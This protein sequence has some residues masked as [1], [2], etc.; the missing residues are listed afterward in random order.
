MAPGSLAALALLAA[1]SQDV[2]ANS[3]TATPAVTPVPGNA[4]ALVM[5]RHCVACHRAAG[6]M[7]SIPLDGYEDAASHASA[8]RAQVVARK[9]PP[10]YADPE[11]SL[12]FGNDARLPAADLGTL[13]AWID[14]GAPRIAFPKTAL[15]QSA[16]NWSDPQG[17]APDVIFTLPKLQLPASGEIPYVRNLIKVSV[18]HDSWISAIQA[19]PGNASV[20]HHMGIAEVSLATG[21]TPGSLGEL[22]DVERRLG[23]PEGTLARPRPSV[24]D[25]F[26]PTLY[27]MLAAYTPGSTYE[28]YAAGSAK[29]LK[30]GP[31]Q[32]ISFNIHY[33]TTGEAAQDQSRLGVWLSARPPA[34]QLF[35]APMPGKTIIANGRELLSDDPG[36]RAEGTQFAIPPIPAFAD[37]F[38]LVGI[39]ALLRPMTIY[40]LQPHAHLRARSFRYAVVYPDGHEQDLL[41]VPEY[42]FHWQLT[43]Q[44]RDPLTLP[45]GSTLVVSARYDNSAHNAHLATAAAL[46]PLRRCGPDKIVRFREQ[47]Q[48]WDEMFSP[49]VE[50]ARSRA[51]HPAGTGAVLKL[52]ATAGCLTQPHTGAWGLQHAHALETATSQST[53]HAEAA[54]LAGLSPGAVTVALMGAQPFN[55]SQWQGQRVLAKGVLVSDAQGQRLNLTSLQPT[56]ARCPQ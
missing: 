7:P 48:T 29:L 43:Y 44:L 31:D 47:N 1:V 28:R 24:L 15:T 42:D 10:W 32:Y 19:L 53:S 40:S 13:V 45:A 38:E 56:G 14:A 3:V 11:H 12:P 27:D 22:K 25:P 23:M 2:R 41:D 50:Y 16:S 18:P 26:D 52:V 51:A 9:M 21:V 17:R 6:S 46:D 39:T 36:T 55:P 54:V 20:V 4:A 37:H 34:R 35:R 33:T 30:S 5:Q 8:I 49:I